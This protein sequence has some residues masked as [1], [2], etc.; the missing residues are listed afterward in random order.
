M[1][2]VPRIRL[3]FLPL[4]TQSVGCT[5]WRKLLPP[6]TTKPE[7]ALCYTLPTDHDSDQRATYLIRLTATPEHAPWAFAAD[8]N[9]QLALRYLFELLGTA[10]T[11][12]LRPDTYT[13]HYGFQ[14]AIAYTIKHTPL[15]NQEIWLEPYYLVATKQYGFLIDFHFDKPPQ[16]P[17]S[18]DV[19]RLSL[20]L[21]EHYRSN[22]NAYIDREVLITGFLQ[23]YLP[24][25]FPLTHAT[26]SQPLDLTRTLTPVTTEQLM[27]KVFV[28]GG[29]HTD[30]SQ[31]KG[32]ERYGPLAPVPSMSIGCI[33][34]YH[35]EHRPLAE[36]L[37]R[38]LMGKTGGVAFKGLLT[39]VPSC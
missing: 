22:K 38:A 10:T 19:Q 13:I 30:A 20:S 24:R 25:L 12:Q 37:Y 27:P 15:G 31:W 6:A 5:L 21:D 32:L 16:T 26:L 28:L 4:A 14:R 9:R 11:E 34:L 39:A 29:G 18:R 1:G 33:M 36:D 7:Q 2:T 17:Y 23:H 3:N 35:R 8:Q